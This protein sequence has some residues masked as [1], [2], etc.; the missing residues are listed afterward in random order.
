MSGGACLVLLELCWCAC[1]K[2]VTHSSFLVTMTLDKA[3][4]VPYGRGKG[5]PQARLPNIACRILSSN[6]HPSNTPHTSHDTSMGTRTH[7]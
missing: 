3:S 7:K 6:F 4:T 5:A 1:K 2:H